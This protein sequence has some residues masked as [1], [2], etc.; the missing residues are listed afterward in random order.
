MFRTPETELVMST[1]GLVDALDLDVALN[2]FVGLSERS[3]AGKS[4][5]PRVISRLAKPRERLSSEQAKVILQ[6]AQ[7]V[8]I[9]RAVRSQKKNRSADRVRPVRRHGLFQVHLQ[10]CRPRCALQ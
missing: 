8:A 6:D 1:S 3:G 2:E 4:T 5:L 10:E 9:V 7:L